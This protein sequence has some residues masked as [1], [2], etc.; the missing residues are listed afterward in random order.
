[1][2]IA[3]V[4]IR[5][6][7]SQLQVSGNNKNQYYDKNPNYLYISSKRKLFFG[8]FSGQLFPNP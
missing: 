4:F 5:S 2:M 3:E 7:I 8:S 6:K 1:V